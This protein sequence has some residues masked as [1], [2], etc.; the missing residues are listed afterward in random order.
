LF[1]LDRG[2]PQR[3]E[4]GEIK[5]RRE[6]EKRRRERGQCLKSPASLA[7]TAGDLRAQCA[8]VLLRDEHPGTG[9]R[10]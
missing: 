7:G 1:F 5:G 8:E 6:R 2:R 9:E 10:G 3:E 4:K